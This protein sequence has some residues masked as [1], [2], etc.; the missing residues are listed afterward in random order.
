MKTLTLA[1]AAALTLASI[2]PLHA[3]SQD[4]CQNMLTLAVGNALDRQG[5][6]TSNICDLTVG[7][8]AAIKSMVEEDGMNNNT[9][10]S[11]ER[12]LATAGG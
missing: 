7:D 11:I 10:Q 2:A 3:Q 5:F 1:T 12:I 9:R 8:L 4:D 6:D